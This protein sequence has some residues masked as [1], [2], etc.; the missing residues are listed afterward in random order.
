MQAIAAPAQFLRQRLDAAQ[1]WLAPLS[2]RLILAYEFG[3]AGLAKLQGQ[4]WFARVTD[5]FPPPFSWIDADLN[6][7][8]ATWVELGAA[9]ALLLGLGTRIAAYA[10]LVLSF[11]AVAA[12][13]WPGEWSSLAELWRGYAIS[14]QGF[15]NYK[16]PLLFV[17]M[18]IPLVLG[19][20]GRLSLDALIARGL[21]PRQQRSDPLAS[22]ALVALGL[23]I[24]LAFLLPL[25]GLA[26]AAFGALATVLW[27]R[28]RR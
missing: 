24:P 25:A 19:G 17:L 20:P 3:E 26:T 13:H 12:V 28:R 2:L 8:L 9:L 27:L 23:G 16:L 4:N 21:P 5:K 15:G 1:P 11:V 6:W 10:L 18:L 22:T 7:F 14:D